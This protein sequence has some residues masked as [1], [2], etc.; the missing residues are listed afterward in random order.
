MNLFSKGKTL[1][2]TAKLCLAINN[3]GRL[4]LE[5]DHDSYYQIQCALFCTSHK[6]C[7]FVVLT[8]SLHIE[9]ISADS[10]FTSNVLLKLRKFCCTV[11]LPE[12]SVT[13]EWEKTKGG[14]DGGAGGAWALPL[15]ETLFK[16][17]MLLE[18][19]GDC[20]FQ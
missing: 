10:N 9:M 19:N 2:L 18:N 15:F 6:W 12:L 3:D 11:I 7:D 17:S 1:L 4:Q 13:K 8:K 5:K 20:G 14:S 16:N